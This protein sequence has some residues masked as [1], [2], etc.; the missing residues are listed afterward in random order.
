M[1]KR[2]FVA[3]ATGDENGAKEIY[4][5]LSRLQGIEAYIPEWIGVAGKTQAQKIIECLESASL[6]IIL[7]TFNS[8]NTMWLNQEIG[9]A[10]ARN[11]P[12]VLVVEKGLDL[13]GFLEGR[14]YITFQRGNFKINIH[15]VVAKIREFFS[16]AK[17]PLTHFKTTCPACKKENFEVL[18]SQKEI[19]DKVELGQRLDYSCIFCSRTFQVDPVTLASMSGT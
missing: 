7:I 9:Y 3:Y 14:P 5:V 2:I 10:C 15:Q 16:Q 11:I 12:V 6:A 4:G 18:P 17:S 1:T 8:T 13:K 19:D